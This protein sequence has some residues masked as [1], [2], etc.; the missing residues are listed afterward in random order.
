MEEETA[1]R[2]KQM[3]GT[4]GTNN[5]NIGVY[6]MWRCAADGPAAARARDREEIDEPVRKMRKGRRERAT[7]TTPISRNEQTMRSARETSCTWTGISRGELVF[8]GT[9]V[10]FS[11]LCSL[12]AAPRLRSRSLFSQP[13]DDGRAT[14]SSLATRQNLSFILH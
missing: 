11:R 7:K 3:Y 8:Y 13:A 10:T 12:I 14:Y 2:H 4:R 6:W 1:C 5:D 9:C